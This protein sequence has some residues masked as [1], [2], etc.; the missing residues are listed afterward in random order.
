MMR[1]LAEFA[2][3]GRRQAVIATVVLGLLPLLNFLSPVLCGLIMLR[4]GAREAALVVVWAILPLAGW[5]IAG[6]GIPL[7]L[8]V[9][10]VV[11]AAVLRETES[12]E[13]TLLGAIGVGFGIE[14]YIRTRTGALELIQQQLEQFLL[15]SDPDPEAMQQFMELVPS[16]FGSAYMSLAVVLLMLSR[17]MQ[18]TLYNPGGFR[19][20][21]HSLRIE[22][23]VAMVLLV[24]M[25]LSTFVE[26][27]PGTW[28]FYLVMP[29]MLA[30][31]A[32]AHGVVG[33]RKAGSMWLFAF[34]M[35][36]PWMTQIVVLAALIDSW[37]DF[38]S[39]LPQQG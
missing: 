33:K 37:Y 39:R 13:F 9:G 28:V 4:R 12:W 3:T 15:A 19:Q 7:L 30:G 31:I 29:L 8:L 18:A 36:L 34:Y 38:R 25:F 27:V 1:G 21:F 32:L 20:E 23:P 11:L 22:R 14:L 16:L 17:W 6:D 10:C 35:L 26:W 24:A 5:A 2:M